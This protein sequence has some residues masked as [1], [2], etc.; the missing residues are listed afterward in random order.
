MGLHAHTDVLGLVVLTLVPPP[1]GP[2]DTVTQTYTAP[3]AQP[4]DFVVVTT[5]A[6]F[7]GTCIVGAFVAVPGIVEV[8]WLNTHN[9]TVTPAPA[10]G[11]LL[12]LRQPGVA[13]QPQGQLL[14]PGPQGPGD[15]A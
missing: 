14:A 13:L 5:L 6:T 12:F 8:T 11:L 3:R 9:Q 7:N 10:P 15:A 1:L 2:N 4:G